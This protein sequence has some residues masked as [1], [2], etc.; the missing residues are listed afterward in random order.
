M[1]RKYWFGI[2]VAILATVV[3]AGS[4]GVPPRPS[5]N[6]YAAHAE[7]DGA[8]IGATRLSASQLRKM[9]AVDKITCSDLDENSVIIE[10]GLYPAK[11]G[12]LEISRDAF[13]LRA[14]DENSRVKPSGA[15]DVVAK[16]PYWVQVDQSGGGAGGGIMPRSPVDHDPVGVSRDPVTGMPRRN[17]GNTAPNGLDG[18]VGL[19]SSSKV[20]QPP[21]SPERRALQLRMAELALPDGSTT[22]P[23]AGL[24]YFSLE[25]KKGVRYQLEYTLNGKKVIL[26]L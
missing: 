4:K 22:S 6:K 17:G 13:T 9:L 20:P 16:L 11:D 26:P 7:S 21:S 10:V 25:Q 5:A 3:F 14:R 1:N 18:G 15:D 12:T 19:G 24:V 2:I 23:L 8:T